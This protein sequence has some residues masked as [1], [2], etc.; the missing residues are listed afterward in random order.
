MVRFIGELRKL[1]M[2]NA[3][4]ENCKMVHYNIDRQWDQR[5][6]GMRL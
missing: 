5:K 6:I 2:L 4:N 1:D 3:H